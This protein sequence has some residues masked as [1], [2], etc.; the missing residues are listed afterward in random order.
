MAVS[1]NDGPE[2]D[3]KIRRMFGPDQV[4]REIRQAIQLCWLGLPENKKS[5]DEVERQIRRIVDRALLDL[6]EDSEAFGIG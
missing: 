5:V 4:D 3:D 2:G 1:S 6:H